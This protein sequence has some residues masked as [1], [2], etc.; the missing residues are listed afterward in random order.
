MLEGLE[1]ETGNI[2]LSIKMVQDLHTC[3]GTWK[4]VLRN[5]AT[6]RRHFEHRPY[7]ENMKDKKYMALW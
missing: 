7:S 1:A 6:R 5:L 4:R 2:K 3:D